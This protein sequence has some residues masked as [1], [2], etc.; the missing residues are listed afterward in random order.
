MFGSLACFFVRPSE[1]MCIPQFGIKEYTCI[2]YSFIALL[3]SS[4]PLILVN[5]NTF[6]GSMNWRPSLLNGHQNH[7]LCQLGCQLIVRSSNRY[8]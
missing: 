4:I 5:R 3:T 1:S 8:E 6:L 2:I 7:A